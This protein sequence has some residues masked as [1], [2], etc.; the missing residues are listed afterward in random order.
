M[1]R[2]DIPPGKVHAHGPTAGESGCLP[3]G[4][5]AEPRSAAGGPADLIDCTHSWESAW[6]DLGGEG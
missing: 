2:I 5:E 3:E 1:A 6:I 4:I